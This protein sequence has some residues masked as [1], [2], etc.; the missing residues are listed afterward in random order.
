[1]WFMKLLAVIL[2]DGSP[3]SLALPFPLAFTRIGKPEVM[4]Y[5]CWEKP[6]Y[7]LAQGPRSDVAASQ[8][9]RQSGEGDDRELKSYPIQ[10]M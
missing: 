10:D 7:S 1:M 4:G 8:G 5:A 6:P 2:E 3:G 9:K